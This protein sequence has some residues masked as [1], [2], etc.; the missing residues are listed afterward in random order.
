ML[1]KYTPGLEQW[2]VTA[3]N[4]GKLQGYHNWSVNVSAVAI[5]KWLSSHVL[6][7][8]K[9]CQA[10]L[11]HSLA[12]VWFCYG[13]FD[14]LTYWPPLLALQGMYIWPVLY[15]DR[16]I[17][18]KS[19]WQCYRA[20]HNRLWLCESSVSRIRQVVCKSISPITLF[21]AQIDDFSSSL[22][23]ICK[24]ARVYVN[25]VYMYC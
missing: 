20:K 12:R 9:K 7:R 15:I 4:S 3:L 22:M 6:L 17:T 8:I 23:F 18:S 13:N 1:S 2:K 21:C 16:N 24:H 10:S 5:T 19:R 11:H 25:C 14:F